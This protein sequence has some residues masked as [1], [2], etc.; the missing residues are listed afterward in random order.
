MMLSGLELSSPQIVI[1]LAML[2]TGNFAVFSSSVEAKDVQGVP[3]A[4]EIRKNC[5]KTDE[6][7]VLSLSVMPFPKDLAALNSSHFPPQ[8]TDAAC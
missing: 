4:I 8:W 7:L 2:F 6:S 1:P 5:S 3:D